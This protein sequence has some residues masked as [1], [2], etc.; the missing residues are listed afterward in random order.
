MCLAARSFSEVLR[1]MQSRIES[2]DLLLCTCVLP[3]GTE[4]VAERAL[5]L[6]LRTALKLLKQ[7]L[8]RIQISKKMFCI[9]APEDSSMLHP[10]A[11][12][13][14]H[15]GKISTL[16]LQSLQHKVDSLEEQCYRREHLPLGGIR[17]YTFFDAIFRTEVCVEVYFSFLEEL[18]V[19]ADDNSYVPAVSDEWWPRCGGAH[20]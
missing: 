9:L 2:L 8:S 16:V 19:G 14:L 15:L 5:P 6:T 11:R 10:R 12:N 7:R 17:E 18:E 1:I 3:I 20:P 13:T 4:R